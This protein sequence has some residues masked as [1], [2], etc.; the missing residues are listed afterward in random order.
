MKNI[1]ILGSA[2]SGKTTLAEKLH[3]KYHY[4]IISI[5]SF[6]TALHTTFP[7]LG[8]SHSNTEKKFKILPQFVYSYMQKIMNEYPNQKFVLEGWHVYPKDIV[9]L[10]RN[11]DDIE[12]IC[13]GYT[14]I[15][16]EKAFRELRNR[17]EENSYT[18]KM[19]DE[20]VKELLKQHKKYSIMLKQ[21]CQKENVVFFDTS[22]KREK[23]LDD[24]V[25]YL[26]QK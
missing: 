23:V 22:T 15:E 1:I 16:I 18:K 8:I 7:D 9:K 25:E 4:S 26:T 14:R 20:S 10:F 13:L 17:E 24:I 3:E 21:Q 12:I 5:D 6:V 11:N 19:T 2:R